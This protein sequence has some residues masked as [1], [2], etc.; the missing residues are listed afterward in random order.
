[1]G[2]EIV[3]HMPDTECQEIE[4][5]D[6]DLEEIGQRFGPYMMFPFRRRLQL[7]YRTMGRL[8]A[9]ATGSSV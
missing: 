4:L 2:V 9:G 3:D 8:L 1:M 7:L 5:R 6:L